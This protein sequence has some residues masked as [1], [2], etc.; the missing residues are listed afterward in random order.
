MST[1]SDD[2]V[3]AKP[4][5]FPTEYRSA[6]DA[7]DVTALAEAERAVARHTATPEQIEGVAMAGEDRRAEDRLEAWRRRRPAAAEH[8]NDDEGA[9]APGLPQ[10]RAPLDPAST[11]TLSLATAIAALIVAVVL[12]RLRRARRPMSFADL[13]LDLRPIDLDPPRQAMGASARHA[14][15]TDRRNHRGT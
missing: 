5:I 13:D 11:R 9:D 12:A 10:H 7:A 6:A 14:A 8:A 3:G 2:E 15:G 1:T 4:D